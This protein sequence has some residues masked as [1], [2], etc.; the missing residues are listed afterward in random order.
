MKILTPVAVSILLLA[1]GCASPEAIEPCLNPGNADGFL[2]GIVQ[3]FIAPV[4]FVVSFFIND[5][6]MYAVNNSGW[7][8]DF[9][10]LIGIGGFSGGIFK[11]R[12]RARRRRD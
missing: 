10:F 7:L 2:M 6:A 3:G 9:G 8:Y 12:K 1:T 11:S 5:V 4:T